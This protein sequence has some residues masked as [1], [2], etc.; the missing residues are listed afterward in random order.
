MRAAAATAKNCMKT[1][2]IA[3][4]ATRS[5]WQ[6]SYSSICSA[7]LGPGTFILLTPVHFGQPPNTPH[8]TD[9]LWLYLSQ[10]L[11]QFFRPNLC[12]HTRCSLQYIYV[13]FDP[14]MVQVWYQTDKNMVGCDTCVFWVH[15][16]CDALAAKAI[17]STSDEP[18]HCPQCREKTSTKSRLAALRKAEDEV[19]KAQPKKPR[20]AYNL[21]SVE[22]HK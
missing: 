21:F 3:R 5:A 13:T 19:R 11:A 2:T 22:I 6:P 1:R 16:H 18:Y 12:V 15:T 4:S 9:T 8:E 20:T 7:Q 10:V 17:N 14:T